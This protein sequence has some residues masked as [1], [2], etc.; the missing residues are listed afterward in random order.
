[1]V[2]LFGKVIFFF[3]FFPFYLFFYL[4]ILFIYFLSKLGCSDITEGQ[5][6]S[7]HS[8]HVVQGPPNI[9]KH[10]LSPLI[11]SDPIISKVASIKDETRIQQSIQQTLQVKFSDDSNITL[12]GQEESEEAKTMKKSQSVPAL[13]RHVKNTEYNYLDFLSQ[14]LIGDDSPF[15]DYSSTLSEF[16]DLDLTPNLGLDMELGSFSEDFSA[17]NSPDLE[18]SDSIIPPPSN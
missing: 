9:L 4:F 7:H 2:E 8:K 13:S 3:L 18:N 1:M 17:F 10:Y 11:S 5:Q 6:A 15:I 14:D 12:N 16:P